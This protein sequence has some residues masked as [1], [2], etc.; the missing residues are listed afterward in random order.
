MAELS[1]KTL[2]FKQEGSKI[3]VNF[4]KIFYFYLDDKLL[5]KI[6][7][8]KI[9]DS[10]IIFEKTPE[11]RA[12]RKFNS[13]LAEGFKDLKNT[14]S[15]K[16]TIYIHK[17]S[18]IPLIGS[19]SFGIVDRNTSI[20][21]VRPITSCNLNCIFCSV[22]AGLSSRNQVDFVV[23][24]EYLVEEF[25]KLVDF[26]GCDVEVHLG[27]QGEPLLYAEI[28]EL[29]KDLS[30]IKKVKTISMD[31]NGTLLTEEL[32]DKLAEAG[33]TRIN[34]SLNAMD[35]NLA[36]KLAGCNYDIEKIKK[37]ASYAAKKI[38]LAIAPVLVPGFNDDEIKKLIEFAKKLKSNRRGYFIGIQNFLNYRF[39]RNPCKQ[40]SWDKFYLMMKDLEKKT[41]T[42]L[43]LGPEDFNIQKTKKLPK[44][45]K[46][47][48]IIKAEILCPGRLKNEMLA[49]ASNRVISIPTCFKKGIVKI[50][51]T[52]TKHNIFMGKLV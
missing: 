23:E 37:I 30:S 17:N 44:P 26:K 20:I 25:K 27:T 45:F 6:G 7:D 2:S 49:V 13:L 8:F 50:R 43:I 34:L 22:D 16:K 31:T 51:I 39:G 21:D 10:S 24:R 41:N 28:I 4:L 33:L 48:Q 1:F 11:K 18:G 40:M 5:S 14:I 47:G 19:N 52:R 35:K 9:K 42:K 32:V 29:I 3:K 38:E 15:G 12:E 36:R 46:K